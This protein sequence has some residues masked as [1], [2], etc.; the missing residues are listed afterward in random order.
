MKSITWSK[1]P[2]PGAIARRRDVAEYKSSDILSVIRHS[3]LIINDMECSPKTWEEKHNCIFGIPAKKKPE[4][5]PY[6]ITRWPVVFQASFE[7]IFFSKFSHYLGGMNGMVDLV[8][9]VNGDDL[10]Y[11]YWENITSIDQLPDVLIT[12]DINSL[13]HSG[14]ANKWLNTSNFEAID[15]PLRSSFVKAKLDH[16]EK[17][18]GVLGADALVM[19]VN[20]AHLGNR[21]VPSEWYEL[22]SPSFAGQIAFCGDRDYSSHSVFYHFIKMGGFEAIEHLVANCAARMHPEEMLFSIKTKRKSPVAIYIMPYSYARII[23]DKLDYKIVWPKDGAIPL[24]I[25][26]LI[27]KGASERNKQEIDFFTNVRLGLNMEQSGLFSSIIDAASSLRK[28]NWVGWDFIGQNDIEEL[29]Q[30]VDKLFS[31][32]F[33]NH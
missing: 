11:K 20:K 19:V 12:T 7:R 10:L 6:I 3:S 21:K 22:L 14:F 17:L 23:N 26:M 28:L 15:L 16:P 13:Y 31:A 4:A 32:K 5:L 29:K 9:S 27:R 8:G 25:Q 1:R 24:P 33:G 2:F 30:A 18:M